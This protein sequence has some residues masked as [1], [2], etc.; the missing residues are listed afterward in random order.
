MIHLVLGAASVYAAIVG[1]LYV[2]QRDLLYHPFGPVTTPAESGVPEMAP[3]QVTAEDGLALTCWHVA[4]RPGRPTIVFF[5]GNAGNVSH[6]GVKVRP[7]LDAG[8]GMLLVGYRGFGG[9]PGSPT[10]E[11]LYADSRAA[12]RYLAGLGVTPAQTI[13][14]GESLGTAVAVHLAA[15]GAAQPVGAVIMESPFTSIV[16]VAQSHYPFVPA[17]LLVKD[18]F[19]SE[20]KIAAVRSP[21]LFIHGEQDRVVPFR[22]GERLFAAAPQPKEGQWIAEA[23]HNDL[24]RFGLSA[25]VIAFLSRL[26]P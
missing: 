15:E 20:A 16:E 4:A 8:F 13:Y 2:F 23:D 5:Q 17:G 25:R 3:V 12:L 7:Y 6:R 1:G 26:F 14:Y 24:H 22:F 9:N 10:E 11:G 18:R 21:L 19:E